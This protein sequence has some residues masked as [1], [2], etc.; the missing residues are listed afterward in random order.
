M[1]KRQMRESH[2]RIHQGRI[3]A[4]DVDRV[5]LPSGHTVDLEIVRHPGSVVLLPMPSANEIVL[6]RQ[7]TAMPSIAGSGNFRREA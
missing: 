5:R 2:R 4:L 6:I 1:T 3:F 7:I